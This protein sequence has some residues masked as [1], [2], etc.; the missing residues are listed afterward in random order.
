VLHLGPS[1]KVISNIL[2]EN[3]G[4][5]GDITYIY[6][7]H[8]IRNCLLARKKEREMARWMDTYIYTYVRATYIHTYIHVYIRR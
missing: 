7:Q 2:E 6:R 4:H 1:D 8:A 5:E 3:C